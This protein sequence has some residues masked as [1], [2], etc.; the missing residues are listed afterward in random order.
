MEHKI[1]N[2]ALATIAIVAFLL[3]IITNG[4]TALAG[5]IITAAAVISLLEL[6]GANVSHLTTYNENDE[7]I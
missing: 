6:N 1:I 4:L 2:F 7:D 5:L 3:T